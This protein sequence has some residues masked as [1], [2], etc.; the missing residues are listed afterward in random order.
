MRKLVIL[1]LCVAMCWC[2]YQTVAVGFSIGDNFSITD[3]KTVSNSS[4][5][6][7]TLISQLAQVNDIQFSQSKSS[8]ANAIKKYK[9]TKEEYE[10]LAES[11]ATE[12]DDAPEI[13][14]VDIYD[15]DFLWTTIGNYGTEEGIS[16]KFNITKSAN[17]LLS[18]TSYTM[19]DLKFTI[20]GDYIPLTDF[21]YDLE[22]D[23]KL[24][25]EISDFELAK[26][27]SNL[28]ATFTVKNVPINNKNL[29]E[30]TTSVTSDNT[31]VDEYGNPI[32][33]SSSTNTNTTTTDTTTTAPTNTTDPNTNTNTN[34]NTVN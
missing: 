14:L 21:I 19:C 13:S 18:T 23:N 6:I 28:Q 11:M 27:G 24:G 20:S 33:D 32:P 15:V 5:E 4:R 2:V 7:D 17:S 1:L 8:L 3:Y 12:D 16:L 29:T 22:D 30:I 10:A 34:T 26:G 31:S 9:D 25:F